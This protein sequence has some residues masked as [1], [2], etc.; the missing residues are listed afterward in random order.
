MVY[1]QPSIEIFGLLIQEPVTTFTDLM[2]SFVCYYAFIKLNKIT[3]KNR[4]H[5]YLKIYFFSMGTATFL[6]GV[7]GHGFLYVFDAQ[8]SISAEYTEFI[9][10]IVGEGNMS[11]TAYPWKLPGWLTSMVSV[12]LL[13]RAVIEYSRKLVSK[14]LG[15]F[16]GWMNII[17]LLIFMTITFTTLNFFFVEVHTFYGLLLVVGSFSTFMFYKTRTKGSRFFVIAVGIAAIAALFFMNEWGISKWFTHSDISHTFMTAA[18]YMF[19]RGSREIIE[20]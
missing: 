3:L 17:E 10:N 8:W 1:Q 4:T 16:F 6:G 20:E 9:A 7:I 11:T 19:Y 5:L 12:A 13:E 14:K 2:V 15:T 18:A